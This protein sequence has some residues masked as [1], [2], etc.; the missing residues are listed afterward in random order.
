MEFKAII[1]VIP[2]SAQCKYSTVSHNASQVITGH[3]I[4]IENNFSH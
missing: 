4:M 1:S 3:G 2:Q